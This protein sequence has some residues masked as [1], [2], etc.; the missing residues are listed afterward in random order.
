MAGQELPDERAA[1][2]STTVLPSA[3]IAAALAR[4]GNAE[5]QYKQARA[6]DWRRSVVSPGA[7]LPPLFDAVL[8]ARMECRRLGVIEEP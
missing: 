1:S 2:P 4:L 3:A 8:R 7:V 5:N 6:R